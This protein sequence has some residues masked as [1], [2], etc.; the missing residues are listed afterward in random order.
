MAEQTFGRISFYLYGRF[1]PK[2]DTK[3]PPKLLK[4]E[5]NPNFNLKYLPN[6]REYLSSENID[7]SGVKNWIDLYFFR[8]LGPM[9]EWEK[10]GGFGILVR[11]SGGLLVN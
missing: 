1:F 11:L 3:D 9:A 7:E 2:S 5:K 8:F 6:N 10:F 4:F